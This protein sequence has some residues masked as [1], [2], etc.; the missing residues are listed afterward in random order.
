[1]RLEEITE[2]V[3]IEKGL[4]GH[5]D[6]ALRLRSTEREKQLGNLRRIDQWVGRDAVAGGGVPGRRSVVNA[7]DRL[8]RVKTG[9]QAT[10]GP[11]YPQKRC[12]GAMSSHGEVPGR[13][14]G[15]HIETSLLRRFTLKAENWS[16]SCLGPTKMVDKWYHDWLQRTSCT[17][18]GLDC[19][20]KWAGNQRTGR[21]E[22]KI[23]GLGC[24]VIVS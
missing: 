21:E 9:I 24:T 15:Q 12:L 3:N 19:W 8:T 10:W 5:K 22:V 16:R 6:W 20:S 23:Q 4:A 17:L 14:W 2:N 18:A 1:M 13:E 11:W 7:A